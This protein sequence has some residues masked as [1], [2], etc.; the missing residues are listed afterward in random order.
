MAGRFAPTPTAALHLGNLRTALAAWLA[1]RSSGRR[2]LIRVEDLDQARVSAARGVAAG[3]LRDL[4]ALGLG[5]D[6]PVVKQSGRTPLYEAA[7]ARLDGLVYECFCSRRDIA[8]AA[9]A[10]HGPDG[11]QPY[12]GVCRDLSPAE[13][14]RRRRSRPPALRVRADAAVVGFADQLAGAQQA[15]VDDFVVRRRDGVFAYNFAVVVDDAD[16]GV[17]QVVRGADLLAT[18]PRQIWLA[19]RLG[20]AVP[21][22]AHVPLAVGPGGRRLAK[23]EGAVGL[24]QALAAGL[25]PGR[26]TAALGR[27]LGLDVPGPSASPADL[28]AGFDFARVPRADWTVDAAWAGPPA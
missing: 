21:A 26:V 12:P 20:L 28:V 2:F 10:P 23:R 6:G 1:A 9:Q 22:Y 17:D 7:L 8:A 16:Q 3:Q 4:A 14:D 13:R 15:T 19:E 27:S 24:S 11:L 25:S 18:T 5:H